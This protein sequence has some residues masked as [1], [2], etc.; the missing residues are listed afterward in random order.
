MSE[1]NSF[2]TEKAKNL[3]EETIQWRTYF[4]ENPE[5]S[6]EEFETAAFLKQ[7]AENCGLKI[8]EVPNS[9][10]FTAL[11][12]TN[13]PGKTLGI[14][15]DMDA[16]PVEEH[17]ENLAGERKYI[18]KNPGVLHACGH[19]GHMAILLTSM[20]ILCGMK[21]HLS[22]KIYFIFEEGEEIGAGIEAMVA[23]LKDK[24]LDAVYGNHLAAFLDSGKVAVDAGPKMSG[25]NLL[26]FTIH[27]ES[28]HASRP[29]LAVNPVFAAAQV[30]TAVTNACANQVD[31]TKTVTLS[32]TQIHGGSAHNVIPNDDSIGGSVSF[33]DVEE[34][35][36][37]TEILTKVA[38][39]TAE[40][41]NCSVSF[42]NNS[43]V[44]ANPVINDA[45]LA[46]I[47]E[48]GVEEVLPG[49]QEQGVDWFASEPFNRYQSLA[50]ALF[51]FIGMRN[52]T[53]GSC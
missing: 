23:H 37:A 13:K 17:A 43:Q 29:D 34:G 15:T 49:A 26:E 24:K 39:L 20:N 2:I 16:L 47:A 5:L 48:K 3:E 11:L 4:H 32:L 28:G 44:T 21:D 7:E 35:K 51:T 38:N 8:E 45:H 18:S 14:R 53:Y 46:E 27:G 41:H 33:Y 1:W 50:P 42:V 40:A 52:E 9:T 30:L 19:D 22:G 25:A 12:D 36:R 31:V 6:S 10:G